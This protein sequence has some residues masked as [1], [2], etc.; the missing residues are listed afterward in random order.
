MSTPNYRVENPVTGKVEETFESTTDAQALEAV[1]TAHAAF[2]SWRAT[3]I[4]ERAKV[5]HQIGRAHV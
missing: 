3:P 1:D 4:E 2:I 5:V